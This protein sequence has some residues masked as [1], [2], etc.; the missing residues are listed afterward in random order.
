MSYIRKIDNKTF[1]YHHEIRAAYPDI[2]FPKA[3]T[4]EMLEQ[5][6]ITVEIHIETPEEGQIQYTF[7]DT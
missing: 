1:M 7:E 6:G 3:I 2:N 5:I 4:D